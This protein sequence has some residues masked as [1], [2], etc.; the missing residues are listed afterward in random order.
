MGGWL[1]FLRSLVIYHNPASLRAWRRFY[2]DLLAPGDLVFDV[3]AHMGTRARAMRR[4]GARVVALEPQA[5]FAGFLRR[6]LPRDIT[7]IEAAA[8]RSDT[9][10]EMAVSSR[11]PTVSS[12][13]TEFVEGA[14]AAPGFGHVKW[15]RRQRVRMV[16]LDGLIAQHG[17]PR[18][19]KIDVEGFEVEVLGGLSAPVQ[20]VSAEYLPAFPEMTHAVI[21]RLAE[22]GDYRF[23]PVAGETGGFLWPD[24]RSADAARDWLDGLAPSAGSGDLFARLEVL[25]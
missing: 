2:R 13:R 16:T 21:D 14:G 6:T 12:L 18:Y 1:G 25:E 11:H 15:D 7:L 5:P 9:E 24:W 23:N 10:A 17:R 3:G 22:L 4:A 8:G 20:I 19:V